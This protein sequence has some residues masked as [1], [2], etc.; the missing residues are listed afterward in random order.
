MI[1]VECLPVQVGEAEVVGEVDTAVCACSDSPAGV[2]E[3]EFVDV[4]CP[5]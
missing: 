1:L 5:G 3:F 4:D 2:F